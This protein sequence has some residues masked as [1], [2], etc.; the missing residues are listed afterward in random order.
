[1]HH[2]KAGIIKI[3]PLED[4]FVGRQHGVVFKHGVSRSVGDRRPCLR[5]QHKG[6]HRRGGV[7]QRF[8][9]EPSRLGVDG[10]VRYCRQEQVVFQQLDIA[11]R[12]HVSAAEINLGQI[13]GHRRSFGKGC[14]LPFV[15]RHPDLFVLFESH[16]PAR[17]QRKRL[18]GI[19]ERKVREQLQRQ[20]V[21][22]IVFPH[23]HFFST[24]L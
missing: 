21:N 23:I 11:A 17:F 5:I 14:R 24:G 4:Q 3:F 9:I 2:A 1:M 6:I 16:F 8:G 10:I 20:Q 22:K 19:Q 18:L 7:F 12:T 15:L 13:M